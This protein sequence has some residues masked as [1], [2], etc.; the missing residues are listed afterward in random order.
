MRK[1]WN[2]LMELMV[3]GIFGFAFAVCGLI[4]YAPYAIF[5]LLPW[6]LCEG[7]RKLVRG[8]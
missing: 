1:L 2:E 3:I 7:A 5:C 6:S 8:N 4:I